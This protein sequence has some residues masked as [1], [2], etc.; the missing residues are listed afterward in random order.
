MGRSIRM[1]GLE[2]SRI[3]RSVP[4]RVVHDLSVHRSVPRSKHGLIQVPN[5][6]L[7]YPAQSPGIKSYGACIFVMAG[8]RAVF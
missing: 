5:I 7:C 2:R 8:A 4:S 6:V 3:D 1:L